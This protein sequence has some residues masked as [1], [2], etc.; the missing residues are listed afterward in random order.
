M[1]LDPPCQQSTLLL[2]RLVYTEPMLWLLA[3]LVAEVSPIAELH[4]DVEGENLLR[5]TPGCVSGETNLIVQHHTPQILVAGLGI[6]RA[7]LGTTSRLLQA[8]EYM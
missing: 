4:P 6:P 1:R 3:P 7:C 8:Y 5:G 2:P